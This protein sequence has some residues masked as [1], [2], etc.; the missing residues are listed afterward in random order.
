[1][2]AAVLEDYNSIC[3]KETEIPECGEEEVI[4][5]IKA[6]GICRTDMKCYTIGQ[7]DLQLPRV[8]GHEITGTAA[9]VGKKVK[10]I[11]TG[12]R[13]QV[14]PGISCG[15]CKYCLEGFENLCAQLEIM[16][17]NYDGGFAEYLKIPSKGVKKGILIP[18]PGNLTYK[19]ASMTEPLACC[20]NMQQA[21]NITSKDTVLIFGAGRFGILNA[22]LSRTLGADK[23]ILVEPDEKRLEMAEKY[24]FDYLINPQKSSTY[25]KIMQITGNKGVDVVIPCC[26]NPEAMNSGLLMAKKKGRIGYFS[27]IIADNNKTEV[28]VNLIHYKELLL[29][30]S[31][32]CSLNHNK[33]ALELLSSKKIEVK[34]M[35]TRIID[36]ENLEIGINKIKNQE[37]LS[38]VVSF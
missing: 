17:F 28:D 26:P 22:K 27:G 16:G 37:E 9:K 5:K 30:G 8:L 25:K 11:N 36:L 19:E 6:T 2:W 23:I 20:L 10:K 14:F 15:K 13:V 1:M 32:G 7:R 33:N 38:I 31:Y 12:D 18:I 35:I 24:E 4:V 29:V 21:L 34:D 3:L